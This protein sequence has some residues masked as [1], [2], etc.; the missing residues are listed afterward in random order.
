RST[1][2][3]MDGLE[4]AG[5]YWKR[6]VRDAFEQV[7][8]LLTEILQRSALSGDLDSAIVALQGWGLVIQPEDHDFLARVGIFRAI[9]TLLDRVRPPA[10]V[11]TPWESLADVSGT[12]PDA[13]ETGETDVPRST[14]SGFFTALEGAGLGW[15]PNE[16]HRPN[17]QALPVPGLQEIRADV[18]ARATSIVTEVAATSLVP[19]RRAFATAD[20]M[21]LAARSRVARAALKVVHLLAG[22]VAAGASGG[23]EGS[24]T[25]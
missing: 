11:R 21:L 1:G 3:Y 6:G 20:R 10:S 24:R 22:Q 8:T 17:E 25:P 12:M 2:H 23:Q 5:L 9:Q 16:R 19:G 15:D 4:A 18:P 13:S 14:S 7:Y